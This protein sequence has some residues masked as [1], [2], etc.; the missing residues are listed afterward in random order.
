[1]VGAILSFPAYFADYQIDDWVHQA[2]LRGHPILPNAIHPVVELFTFMDGTPAWHAYAVGGGSVPWY[3][4]PDM[5]ANLFRPVS[6]ATHVLDHAIAPGVP[7]VAHAHNV[8][9]YAIVIV[10]AT[11]L[12]RMVYRE[13]AQLAGTVGGLAALIFALDEAHGLPVAWIANRNGIITCAFG[14]GV[15]MLHRRATLAGKWPL[16]AFALLPVGLLAGE[17]TLAVT[18]YLFAHAVFL[19]TGSWRSRLLR[20][21]PYGVI[22][23]VWRV[24]YSW[25]GY[26]TRGSGLYLDPAREPLAFALGLV[27]RMPLLLGDQWTGVPALQVNFFDA[28]LK[29]AVVAYCVLILTGLGWLMWR[30]V[31]K[32]ATARFWALGMLLATIPICATFPANRLLWFVGIGAAGLL[33]EFLV[34]AWSAP[35]RV[36]RWVARGLA[37]FHIGLAPLMFIGSAATVDFMADKMF[38]TCE[39]IVPDDPSVEDKVAVFVNSNALCAGH[40]RVIR[41]VQGGHV[42]SSSILMASAVVDVEVIGI[43]E[44]TVEVRPEGGYHRR[45]PDQLFR[46]GEDPMPVG[47]TVALDDATVTIVEHNADGYAAAAR[48]R[49]EVPLR[50]PKLI[51]RSYEDWQVVEFVPPAP[52]ERTTIRSSLRF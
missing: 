35:G 14:I 24:L 32:S 3:T 23:V 10:L 52:G 49:F 11:L 9:W 37:V 20:L 33:A 15:L 31:G 4:R 36:E 19:E 39:A 42:W 26:G 12:F 2:R 22:V 27:E 43:D 34:E 29:W 40:A 1:M 21:V 6:S 7:F 51:W 45:A 5:L 30:R 8:L 28:G 38:E 48:F 44:H 47:A 46:K 25:Y 13:R 41:A 16:A 50:D 18:A 17:A